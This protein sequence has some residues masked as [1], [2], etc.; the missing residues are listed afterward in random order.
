MKAIRIKFIGDQS[1]ESEYATKMLTN[2]AKFQSMGGKAASENESGGS[3]DQ[4]NG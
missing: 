3:G 2:K 1:K 4:N